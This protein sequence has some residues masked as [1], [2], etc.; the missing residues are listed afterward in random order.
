MGGRQGPEKGKC[1]KKKE[2]KESD[3]GDKLT[4]ASGVKPETEKTLDH[5]KLKRKDPQK[6]SMSRGARF[7]HQ[8][9]VGL[10]CGGKKKKKKNS[11]KHCKKRGDEK[12]STSGGKKT[13]L[14]AAQIRAGK[15]VGGFGDEDLGKRGKGDRTGL[16]NCEEPS[17]I[18]QRF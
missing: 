4:A 8:M 9:W 7:K 6:K 1:K 17:I 15:R 16:V 14:R 11:A 12:R 13:A 2:E 5:Q 3:D 18:K 10:G